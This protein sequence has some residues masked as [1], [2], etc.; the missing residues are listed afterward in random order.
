[1]GSDGMGRLRFQTKYS[2]GQRSYLIAAGLKERVVAG[3]RCSRT[4]ASEQFVPAQQLVVAGPSS[5]LRTRDGIDASLAP[6]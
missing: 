5:K 6:D 4:D 1:V 2:K 3:C